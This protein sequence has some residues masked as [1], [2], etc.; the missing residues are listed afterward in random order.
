MSSQMIT[1]FGHYEAF[2]ETNGK[3]TYVDVKAIPMGIFGNFWLR[4]L[5][6]YASS[7]MEYMSHFILSQGD[8]DFRVVFVF[9]RSLA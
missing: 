5:N 8:K 6:Y 2:E 1:L 9:K 3:H 4:L 7:N